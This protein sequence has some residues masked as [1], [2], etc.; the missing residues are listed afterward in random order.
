MKKLITLIS[1][2][3]L[4][5]GC[6]S[7]EASSFEL[8]GEIVKISISESKGFYEINPNF[9]IELKDD[10]AIEIITKAITTAEKQ[11]GS[12]DMAEPEYDMR[13]FYDHGKKHDFHLWIEEETTLMELENTETTY[14]ISPEMTKTLHNLISK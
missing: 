12:V 4:L 13:V 8:K 11:A 5:I 2:S 3:V 10:Y 9:F 14:S 7:K 6:H 1:L